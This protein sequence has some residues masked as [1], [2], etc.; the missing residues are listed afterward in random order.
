MPPR[1]I[2][3]LLSADAAGSR[4]G[5]GGAHLGRASA[6]FEIGDLATAR[7]L[8]QRA[9]ADSTPALRVR[10][11]LFLCFVDWQAGAVEG[12]LEPWRSPWPQPG[13]IAI[14]NAM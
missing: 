7:A 14:S 12:V 13:T 4:G 1:A 6:V 9:V 2:R 11:L 10:A 3:G 5:A 8:T